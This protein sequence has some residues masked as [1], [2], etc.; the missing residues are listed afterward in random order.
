MDFGEDHWPDYSKG[1]TDYNIM[2]TKIYE[3]NSKIL[4]FG[5]KKGLQ[6]NQ[7]NPNTSLT[8]IEGFNPAKAADLKKWPDDIYMAVTKIT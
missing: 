2:R 8:A 3:E 6:F 5:I 7:W 1:Y 4:D